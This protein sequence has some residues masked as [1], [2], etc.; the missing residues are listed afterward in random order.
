MLLELKG[1]PANNYQFK[2]TR[3]SWEKEEA[4]KDGKV[5][6]N[7]IIK[8]ISD[9]TIQFEI[10]AWKDDFAI[11]P[12]EH[13]ASKQ[14][15]VMDSVFFIPQLNRTRRIWVYLPEGYSKSK[16]HYPVMYMHDGQNLFDNYT[17][18]FI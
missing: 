5:P 11:L 3:G 2:F 10:A 12:R 9:T 18:I 16:K 13:T 15:R 7:K 6:E 14:V 17:A 8:L 4:T 1:L